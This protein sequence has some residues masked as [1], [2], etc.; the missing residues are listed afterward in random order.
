MKP[1][2]LLDIDGVLNPVVRP[3]ADRPELSLPPA[4]A[5]LVRRLARCGRLAW[6]STWRRIRREAWNRSWRWTPTLCV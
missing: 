6:V 2:I 1:I 3:G 4:T 5:A